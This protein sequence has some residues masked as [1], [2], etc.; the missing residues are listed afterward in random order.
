MYATNKVVLV[1]AGSQISRVNSMW[2]LENVVKYKS[3]FRTF[4]VFLPKVEIRTESNGI[5]IQSMVC[6]YVVKLNCHC[7]I[8]CFTFCFSYSEALNSN[9]CWFFVWLRVYEL[10]RRHIFWLRCLANLIVKAFVDLSLGQ[11]MNI[12]SF[13]K[14][15]NL[16]KSGYLEDWWFDF[17]GLG[18]PHLGWLLARLAVQ[19]AYPPALQ[20]LVV[21]RL[22]LHLL[23]FVCGTVAGFQAGLLSRWFILG[24]SFDRLHWFHILVCLK[25]GPRKNSKIDFY[26]GASENGADGTW[27]TSQ[28]TKGTPSWIGKKCLLIV[29]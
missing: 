22:G 10:L 9:N 28:S 17:A 23:P 18:E 26:K 4:L 24:G 7:L 25:F 8:C 27:K 12:F 6:V 15:F 11:S 20:Q 29:E 13:G 3:S 19:A 2:Y 16:S 21:S 14:D 5:V 1:G